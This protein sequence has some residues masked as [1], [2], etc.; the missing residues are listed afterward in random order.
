MTFNSFLKKCDVS[1][2]IAPITM[3]LST[4]PISPSSICET[5]ALYQIKLDIQICQLKTITTIL[6]TLLYSRNPSNTFII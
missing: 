1:I 6:P 5:R 4:R 3:G 2:L